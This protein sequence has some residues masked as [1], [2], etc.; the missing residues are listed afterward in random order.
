MEND[1]EVTVVEEKF[2]GFYIDT[3]PAPV[4]PTA[5]QV[6]RDVLGDED[7]E[8]IVYVAPHPRAGPAS[9]REEMQTP[10]ELP[11]ASILTGLVPKVSSTKHPAADDES[12]SF[13]VDVLSVADAGIHQTPSDAPH[14][15]D[16]GGQT[17]ENTKAVPEAPIAPEA[18]PGG[19]VVQSTCPEQRSIQIAVGETASVPPSTNDDVAEVSVQASHGAAGTVAD[20]SA[21]SSQPVAVKDVTFS[22][23]QSTTQKK[24]TRRLHPVRTPRA[25]INRNKARRK[26]LRGF[27]SFGASLAEAHLREEDPRADERRIGDSDL[28]WGDGS[29][30]DPVE[31]LSNGIGDMELDADLD[32]RAMASFVKSMSA[33]GSRAVTMDDIADAARMQEEDE[34]DAASEFSGDKNSSEEDSELEEVMQQQEDSLVAESVEVVA[35][36]MGDEEDDDDDD[37]DDEVSSEDVDDS[38]RRGFEA[39]LERIRENA[40]G[41]AKAT[42]VEAPDSDE[43]DDDFDMELEQS[44]AEGDEEFIAHIQV[45]GLKL[46]YVY[47]FIRLA[48]A[49]R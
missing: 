10:K 17:E 22:F 47:Q 35:G 2:T 39:R 37:D 41:K 5:S 30:A 29:D 23:K 3:N 16:P 4:R 46:I 27:S 25:L 7:D 48:G 11:T 6:T 36:S 38:P 45:R 8:I 43:D 33:E 1:A 24:L 40:K 44:W 18:Q 31:E 34:D 9:P 21:P 12:R 28:D 49:R 19:Y 26:P 20:D 14:S 42:F 32:M 13:T 15:E